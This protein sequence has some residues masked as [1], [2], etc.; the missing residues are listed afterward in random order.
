MSYWRHHATC[1]FRCGERQ[2][3]IVGRGDGCTLDVPGR[4]VS[5]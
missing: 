4:A 1:A 5:R 2:V 3:V